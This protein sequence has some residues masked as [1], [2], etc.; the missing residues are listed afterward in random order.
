MSSAA[1]QTQITIESV[2]SK[3]TER[4][5]MRPRFATCRHCEEEFDVT[6]NS[7]RACRWHK[8]TVPVSCNEARL[9]G[10]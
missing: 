8:G 7:D 3:G 5:R 2:S 4:K 6:E 1:L 9:M 10:H